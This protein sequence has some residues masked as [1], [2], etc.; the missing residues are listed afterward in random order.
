MP[1]PSKRIV[2]TGATRGLG[3]ALVPALAAAGHTV[4]GCGRSA[5]LVADLAVRFP[6]PNAFAAV[7]VTDRAAVDAWAAGVMSLTRLAFGLLNTLR[8]AVTACSIGAAS[9]KS[10]HLISPS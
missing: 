5:S 9:P 4:F 8:K 6:A 10:A 7:D 2:L 1:M 3:R